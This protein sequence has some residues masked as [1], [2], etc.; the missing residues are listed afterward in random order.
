MN[1]QDAIPETEMSVEDARKTLESH[2]WCAWGQ[3]GPHD[4]EVKLAYATLALA[5]LRGMKES[6]PP[7]LPN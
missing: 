1:D 6:A 7:S 5:K 4:D 2:S 3:G